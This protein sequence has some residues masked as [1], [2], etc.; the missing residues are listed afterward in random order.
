MYIF[1]YFIF[2]GTAMQLE[3]TVRQDLDIHH[4]ELKEKTKA[5][6]IQKK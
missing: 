2:L 3:D 4:R 1:I 5:D 6:L